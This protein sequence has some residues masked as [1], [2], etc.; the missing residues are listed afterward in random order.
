MTGV[1]GLFKIQHLLCH[2]DNEI[3]ERML[4][5][6]LGDMVDSVIV[7]YASIIQVQRCRVHT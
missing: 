3:F 7:V 1:R 4:D 5:L 2:H 6:V